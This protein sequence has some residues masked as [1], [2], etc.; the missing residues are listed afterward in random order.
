MV[1]VSKVD[2]FKDTLPFEQKGLP[3]RKCIEE[4]VLFQQ[5][6]MEKSFYNIFILAIFMVPEKIINLFVLKKQCAGK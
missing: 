2:G 4:S 6:K 3:R 1:L 5:S